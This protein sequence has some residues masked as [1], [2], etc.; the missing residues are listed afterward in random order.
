MTISRCPDCVRFIPGGVGRRAHLYLDVIVVAAVA[1]SFGAL[2]GG[3]RAS[4]QVLVVPSPTTSVTARRD[5]HRLQGIANSETL[6]AEIRTVP[7]L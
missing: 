5:E 7:C 6:F 2:R 3:G 1:R 4:E